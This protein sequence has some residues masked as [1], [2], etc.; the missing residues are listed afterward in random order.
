MKYKW[1]LIND[2]PLLFRE[3]NISKTMTVEIF[4]AGNID[5]LLTSLHLKTLRNKP[6]PRNIYI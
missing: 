4:L 3:E 1:L 6:K 2:I 5:N